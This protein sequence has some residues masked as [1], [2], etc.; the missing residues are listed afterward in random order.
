MRVTVQ[1]APDLFG[2]GGPASFRSPP[3]ASSGSSV[4]GLKMV[5][6][7]SMVLY[8]LEFK[9]ELR[10]SW[11]INVKVDPMKFSGNSVKPGGVSCR[12]YK[13]ETKSVKRIQRLYVHISLSSPLTLTH[14]LTLTLPLSFLFS[15]LSP[16]LSLSLS[17]RTFWNEVYNEFKKGSS[18]DSSPCVWGITLDSLAPQQEQEN[19]PPSPSRQVLKKKDAFCG[20]HG[21]AGYANRSFVSRWLFVC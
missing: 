9:S 16:S 10:K 1:P 21:S 20:N 3:L 2:R 13:G 5:M 17:S 15:Y 4:T 7:G 14:S 6:V 11:K 18:H 8:T 19:G 12:E